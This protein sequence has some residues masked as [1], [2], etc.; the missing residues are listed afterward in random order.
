MGLF[1]FLKKEPADR[2]EAPKDKYWSLTTAKG[3][4][5]D[6]IWEQIKEALADITHQELEFVSLGCIHAD[7]EIEMIQAVDIGEGYRLE[8]LPSESSSDYGKVFV[9]GGISY[10]ELVNQFEEFHTNKKV[11]GFRSW[12]S[13]KI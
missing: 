1:D 4:V 6:P 5:I 9:N 11:M 12:P 13:E 7:L 8:A 2:T 10:E 3:E